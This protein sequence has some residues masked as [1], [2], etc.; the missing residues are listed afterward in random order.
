MKITAIK[1]Q[2]KNAERVSIYID[3][4]YSFSLNHTQ[5]LDLKL[6]IG[7]EVNQSR[8]E[9]F[10][11]A[12]D[13]GKIYERLMHYVFMRPRSVKEVEDYCRRK[14]YDLSDCQE[15]IQKLVKRGYVNDEA[16]AKSWVENRRLNKAVSERRLRMELMQKGIKSDAIN[17]A[18]TESEYNQ[19]TALRQLATKKIRQTKYQDSK[20]LL[21]YLMA[22]G[23]NYDDCKTVVAEMLILAEDDLSE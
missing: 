23:F 12:S 3:D 2:V 15:I 11:K 8:L 7:L 19:L 21:Q 5:L 4:S 6:R 22:Q 14:R 18:L 10:K 20:K 17:R 9:E 1:A 13:F 16:F